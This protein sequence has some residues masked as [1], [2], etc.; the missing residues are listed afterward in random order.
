MAYHGRLLQLCGLPG[1]FHNCNGNNERLPGTAINIAINQNV[2]F[3]CSTNCKKLNLSTAP[4]PIPHLSAALGSLSKCEKLSASYQHCICISRLFGCAVAGCEYCCCSLSLHRLKAFI[5]TNCVN[6]GT[7]SK[8]L[9]ICK[10]NGFVC[11]PSE[12]SVWVW[13]RLR[14]GLRLRR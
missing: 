9:F 4:F 1:Q 14:L 2:R 7:P 13:L 12:F 8:S 10:F 5:I 6:I 3:M 11:S